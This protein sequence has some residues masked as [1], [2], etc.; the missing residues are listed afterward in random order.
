MFKPIPANLKT[1]FLVET[2]SDAMPEIQRDGSNVLYPAFV[3]M[4]TITDPETGEER[5][6]Y[7]YF[8]VSIPYT[9]QQLDDP[10]AF[11]LANY[12]AL[13]KFFYGPQEVQAELRDD[14]AWE[15]HRQAV[16]SSFPKTIGE[17]NEQQ[18]RFESIKVAFWEIIDAALATIEKSRSDLPDYFNA[19]EMLAWAQA[20]GMDAA[21]IQAV[22]AQ[23]EIV[24]LDLLHNAR[25][26]QELFA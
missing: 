16:R 1:D 22:A 25:N 3:R 13:R 6:N 15:P 26:W 7:R 23:V 9:G 5:K 21:T 18:V 4:E 2:Q 14:K 24:S 10:Q 17:I 12:A 11:E 19:E 8:I 20:N